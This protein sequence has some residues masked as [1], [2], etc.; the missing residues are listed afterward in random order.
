MQFCATSAL[1]CRSIHPLYLLKSKLSLALK[2]INR[3]SND[4]S[5]ALGSNVEFSADQLEMAPF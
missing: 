3:A 2:A 4:P 5:Q 1:W